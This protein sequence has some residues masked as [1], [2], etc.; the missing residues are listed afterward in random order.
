ML[1]ECKYFMIKIRTIRTIRTYIQLI[2]SIQMFLVER[3]VFC[4]YLYLHKH[5]H[6]HKSIRS[7]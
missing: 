1:N 5:K 2:D 3:V 4:F 7:H 6:K